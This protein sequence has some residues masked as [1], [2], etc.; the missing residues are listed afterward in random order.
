MHLGHDECQKCK[1]PSEKDSAD[2]L[3]SMANS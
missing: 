2:Y 3:K 1:S